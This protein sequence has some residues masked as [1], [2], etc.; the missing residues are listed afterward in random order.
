MVNVGK[1]KLLISVCCRGWGAFFPRMQCAISGTNFCIICTG[2]Y[3]VLWEQ[4]CPRYCE[5]PLDIFTDSGA[6][7]IQNNLSTAVISAYPKRDQISAHMPH[8]N[9]SEWVTTEA[10]SVGVDILAPFPVTLRVFEE[11]HSVQRRKFK[12]QVIMRGLSRAWGQGILH[13]SLAHPKWWTGRAFQLYPNHLAW[14]L[15]WKTKAHYL[16]RVLWAVILFDSAGIQKIHP[17]IPHVWRDH[18][19]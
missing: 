16:V 4:E 2:H 12:V 3:K 10:Y 9:S 7:K 17:K 5:T 15:G 8:I 6:F 18:Y 11:L 19:S 1:Y 13:H 14:H